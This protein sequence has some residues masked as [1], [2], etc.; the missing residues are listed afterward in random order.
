[1]SK[2]SNKAEEITVEELDKLIL[3]SFP[4]LVAIHYQRMLE[5]PTWHDK[6][7][8]C[9][10]VFELG[11][12]ALTL[13][14]IHEYLDRD[15]HVISDR[16]LNGLLRNRFPQAS[17]GTWNEIFFSILKAY[18]GERKRFFVPELYDL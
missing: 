15:L 12:R 8:I 17:L 7:D 9:L 16:Y 1:M 10:K 11:L 18:K 13:Q 2:A 4:Y 5:A 6:T 3:E 14:M